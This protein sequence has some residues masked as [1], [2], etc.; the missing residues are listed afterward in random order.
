MDPALQKVHARFPCAVV[1]DDHEVENSY[2]GLIPDK[3][4]LVKGFKERRAAAYRAYYE[5]MPLRA[6]VQP[7]DASGDNHNNWVL[8][9]KR[10][11]N[12]ETSA[13]LRSLPMAMERS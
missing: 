9:V 7:H 3:E 4:F 8:D 10:D 11:P 1:S 12:R 6:S 13:A 5:H 2:A